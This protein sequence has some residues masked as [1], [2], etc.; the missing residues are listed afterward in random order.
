VNIGV[1]EYGVGEH[2]V[3]ECG[4]GEKGEEEYWLFSV[5]IIQNISKHFVGKIQRFRVKPL[6]TSTDC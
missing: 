2:G 4:V 1:D 3:D 5:K 6:V